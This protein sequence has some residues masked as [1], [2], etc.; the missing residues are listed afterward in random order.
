MASECYL[1]VLREK[2]Y[3]YR[4]LLHDAFVKLYTVSC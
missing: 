2:E 3:K 1:D 4:Q